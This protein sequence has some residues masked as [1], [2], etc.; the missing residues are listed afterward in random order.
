MNLYNIKSEAVEIKENE[1]AIIHY[2]T[3]KDVDWIGDV[4][5][6]LGMNS[7]KYEKHRVVLYNHESSKPIG[8]NLWIKPKEEGVLVS[9][10][11]SQKSS[12]AD[13][14]FQLHKEGIINT[15]SIGWMPLMVNGE[16]KNGAIQIDAKTNIRYINEWELIEY[17][18]APLAMNP[19]ALDVVKSFGF[20]SAELIHEIQSME[21][22][23]ALSERLKSLEAN[24]EAL[25][26]EM[27]N[28]SI[29]LLRQEIQELKRQIT[30]SVET[31]GEQE[32]QKY[33]DNIIKRVVAGEVSRYLQK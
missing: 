19:S 20:K 32:A 10:Y 6:P 21:K 7:E 9:T 28:M 25:Q 3:T 30:K 12:F 23:L 8:K 15:W 5:N 2:I 24:I 17:S 31:L 18:S 11:F 4:V 27:K 33:A 1:R 29:D 13:E 16:V 14:V 22:E 26:K